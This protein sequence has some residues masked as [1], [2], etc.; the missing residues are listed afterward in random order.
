VR[1]G[2]L[3][4]LVASVPVALAEE[5]SL[6]SR[7]LGYR[8]LSCGAAA[9]P[10]VPDA[11]YGIDLVATRRVPGLGNAVGLGVVTFAASPYGVSVTE[12]G[13]YVHD[14]SLSLERL[15]A[16]KNGVLTAW[17]ASSDL[18]RVERLGVFDDSFRVDGRV[19]WNRFLVVVTL[20]PSPEPTDGWAGPVV[21][22]GM[23]RSG[24][25]HTMA[26]HGPFEKEPCA[27]YGFR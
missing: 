22:R 19:S 11:Y 25:M 20:E 2:V 15:K 10:D 4:L 27:K 18:S 14:V 26:G 1:L 23:S 8:G 7:G 9:I 3:F 21:L 5:P 13:E 16:P 6:W 17:V 24:M 12:A